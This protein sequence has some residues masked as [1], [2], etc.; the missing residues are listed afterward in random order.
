[1]IHQVEVIATI[2]LSAVFS[3]KDNIKGDD[4]I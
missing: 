2:N 4:F 3:E 1:M